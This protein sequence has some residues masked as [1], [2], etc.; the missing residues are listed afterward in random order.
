MKER[1]QF[2]TAAA[3]AVDNRVNTATGVL[4]GVA[5][6]TEGPARGHADRV[7]GKPLHVDQKT[8]LTVLK[9][10]REFGASGPKVLMNH[11]GGAGDIV[12]SLRNFRIEGK[13]LRADL[14]LLN[15]TPHRAYVLEVAETAPSA[16]ALSVAF[17]GTHDVMGDRAFA[18][19]V[20]LYSVDL[21]A[22]AAANAALFDGV[23]RSPAVDGETKF[24][25][26]V[27]G[28]ARKHGKGEAIRLA[29][30]KY[31]RSHDDYLARTNRPGAKDTL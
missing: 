22:E 11:S 14:H 12:G 21:V 2:S 25:D 16:F 7:S 23:V 26:L 19:C 30:E 27:R 29:A 8:L 28:L 6:I 4:Y 13:V 10:A 3:L 20:E 17:S 15:S 9:A 18:R 24:E 31:P 5:V 1:H